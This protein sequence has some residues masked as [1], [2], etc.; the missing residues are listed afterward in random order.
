MNETVRRR[1][2]SVKVYL[3]SIYIELDSETKTPLVLTLSHVVFIR[4][5]FW[6]FYSSLDL[7][8]F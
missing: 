1:E 8:N 4:I 7:I 3:M 2:L 6:E 5:F